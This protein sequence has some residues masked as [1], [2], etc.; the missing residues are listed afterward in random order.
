MNSLADKPAG[1]RP[2]AAFLS[3]VATALAGCTLLNDT[4]TLALAP[5]DLPDGAPP[6]AA[7]PDDQGRDPVEDL[8]PDSDLP[9][10]SAEGPGADGPDDPRGDADARPDADDADAGGDAADDPRVPDQAPDGDAGLDAAVD[11][12]G[13]D[14]G[15]GGVGAPCSQ[16]AD[17]ADPLVCTT[18]NGDGFC[19]S[20]CSKSCTGDGCPHCPNG[21]YC[22][23]LVM[24]ASGADI[25]V[26]FPNAALRGRPCRSDSGCGH[27]DAACV[28]MGD[29]GSFC[30][31]RCGPFDACGD[32]E[33]CVPGAGGDKVCAPS[34]GVCAECPPLAGGL[35]ASTSCSRTN[36]HGSCRAERVCAGGRLTACEARVPAAEECDGEDNDCDGAIDDGA[37]CD[38]GLPCTSDACTIGACTHAIRPGACVIDDGC[39]EQGEPRPGNACLECNAETSIDSWSQGVSACDDGDA[40]TYGDICLGGH[41]SGIGYSCDDD[42]ACTADECGGQGGCRH[43]LRPGACLI[44]QECVAE[45]TIS[46]LDPCLRCVPSENVNKWTPVPACDDGDPCTRDD[47]CSAGVCRGTPYGCDD[48]L[49]CTLDACDGAGRCLRVAAPGLCAIAGACVPAGQAHPANPCLACDPAATADAWSPAGGGCDDGDPCTSGDACVGGACRGAAYGCDDGLEC[50]I[51]TCDGL[52]GCAFEVAPDACAIE[53]VCRVAGESNGS[54]PCIVCDPATSRTQWSTPPLPC[55]DADACT[56]GDTCVAGECVTGAE[57]PSC[58]DGEP[59]TADRCEPAVGCVHEPADGDCDDHD[60][61]TVGDRCAAGACAGGPSTCDCDSDGDCADDANLCNG[62]PRCDRTSFPYHCAPTPGTVVTCDVSTDGSCARTTCVPSIGACVRLPVNEGSSC[63][64]G[65]LCTWGERCRNGACTGGQVNDCDDGFSCT[66]DECLGFW[67]CRNT[68]A[69]GT[70]L[71]SGTCRV[72]GEKR[73]GNPCRECNPAASQTQW[74]TVT[75]PYSESCYTGPAGTEGVFPC[76]AGTR[77]CQG[78]SLGPCTGEVVP[79][80]ETCNGVDDDCDGLVDDEGATGCVLYSY[81]RD[82]D[83]YGV[84]TPRCLCGPAGDWRAVAGGDCDDDR[85]DANPGHVETCN[86]ADDDCDGIADEEGAVGCTPF[87]ADGDGDGYG[88]DSGARCL[89]SPVAPWTL[90]SGG[91]CDDARPDVNPGRTEDP[92]DPS[93]TDQDCDGI[94]GVGSRAVFVSATHGSDAY[95]GSES[96]PKASIAAGIEAAAASGGARD[97]VFVDRGTYG[98]PVRLASG[99]SVVGGYTATMGEGGVVFNNR[100]ASAATEVRASVPGAFPG[101]AA[102]VVAVLA[103]GLVA[104]T[105]LVGLRIVAAVPDASVASDPA[106]NTVGVFV[107]SGGAWLA[108]DGLEVVS[109]PGG[110]GRAGAAGADGAPGG[111]GSPGAPSVGSTVAGAMPGGEAGAGGCGGPGGAGGD[112]RAGAQGDAG[113]SGSGGAAGG[114]E[115]GSGG[116][117]P[118]DCQ[119][120]QP[121]QDGG[122]GTAGDSGDPGAEASPVYG[123]VVGNEWVGANGGSG[124]AAGG[125][126]EGGGGG[127]AAGSPSCA[128]TFWLGGSGGG[129]G[130][131]GCGGEAG[132]GGRAGGGAFAVWI[133]ADAP[134]VSACTMRVLGGGRGGR[135]GDGGRPGAGGG[136]GAGGDA[137]GLEYGALGGAGGTGGAGGYGGAGAG[138]AGGVSFGIWLCAGGSAPIPTGVT[139]E[140]N[141]GGTGGSGGAGAP[142][143]SAPSGPAGAFGDRNW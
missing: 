93:Y 111:Q 33:T 94:D 45:G 22:G 79:A 30:L 20:G 35:G 48:G 13:S 129:G 110:Q 50:T 34:G 40:C 139:Y 78:S 131:C 89:C 29:A 81:D 71:I 54:N 16:D 3:A 102:T 103:D 60:P 142:G 21:W 92:P 136:G 14:A 47:T 118:G 123:T 69:A 63:H 134:A 138:G 88:G 101:F 11:P 98:G 84:G 96:R 80:A 75:A 113:R 53:G 90:P 15:P 82:G 24:S 10:D 17:C 5:A 132:G 7:V 46:A 97:S 43:T 62:V 56:H 135:G 1:P 65:N 73:P 115:G 125:R 72:A 44:W 36:E 61:C 77:T 107:G 130:G 95:D 85:A 112:S 23:E 141:P 100:S 64:D 18:Q 8:R 32:G 122:D 25:L 12:A 76:R 49:D 140:T 109:G 126:G 42:L 37:S 114:G 143:R 4:G 106:V 2:M 120:G 52:G 108:L 27:G 87:H 116:A 70:C 19:T 51:G 59:C 58:D 57:V 55:D 91:D 28:R 31:L 133:R 9:D 6:D 86:L 127:G 99:V 26:C 121:G 117:V 83:G 38:D 74:S 128:G 105:A 41:C 67:S 137:A 124:S 39:R 119:A 68:I 66:V 104:P